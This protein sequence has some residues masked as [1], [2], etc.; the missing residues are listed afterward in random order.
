MKVLHLI[1]HLGIGGAQS[2]LV[3][4]VESRGPD[5]ETQ[6]V[7]LS[8]RELP[9]YARRIEAAGVLC[10][11]LDLSKRNPVGL[12][13]LRA[14]LKSERPD[15]LHTHLDFS[16]SFGVATAASLGRERPLVVRS[17][18]DDPGRKYAWPLRLFARQAARW[19]DAEVAV[20]SSVRRSAERLF[21]S[22]PRPIE[23]IP[24]GLDLQR[25]D[26]AL[27]GSEAVR[28]LRLG[29]DCV[30]GTVARLADQKGLSTLLEAMPQVTAE[31]GARLLIVGDGP[32]RVRLERYAMRLGLG[33]S[34]SFLGYRG[35]MVDVYAAMDVF[36]LPSRHEGFGVVFI[37]AMAM[38]VPVVGT[39]VVG[40][41]DAIQDRATGLLVP[42][43]DPRALAE[44]ILRL[45]ADAELATRLA[46]RGAGWVR[47]T[48]SR[49]AMAAN[50]EELYRRLLSTARA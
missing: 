13:K 9:A 21:P 14:L 47:S 2:Q 19:V 37:E 48:R 16:N 29:A 4:L 31:T 23:V 27:V 22:G 44:A 32:R 43:D 11:S 42:P 18:D 46:N 1:D 36:A 6:I 28:D 24:P 30:V 5:V 39:R 50:T 8:S 17:I 38:G 3:D 33:G 41:V 26:P 10:R 20:S 7:A 45:L 34:V 15:L 25:F 12:R 49:E 35:D 40:T